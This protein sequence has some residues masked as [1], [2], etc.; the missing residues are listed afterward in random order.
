M[1]WFTSSTPGGI[2]LP[3]ITNPELG[4]LFLHTDSSND[5]VQ[6]W[7]YDFPGWT[8]ITKEYFAQTGILNPAKPRR[9]LMITDNNEPNFVI[10]DTFKKHKVKRAAEKKVKKIEMEMAVV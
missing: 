1:V 10:A 9:M 2:P 8:D 5:S 3:P 4:S 7:L 6:V